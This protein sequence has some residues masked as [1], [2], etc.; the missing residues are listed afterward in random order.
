MDYDKIRAAAVAVSAEKAKAVPEYVAKFN[1]A[2]Q[3][4]EKTLDM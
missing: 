1:L 3:A 2:Q 4:A